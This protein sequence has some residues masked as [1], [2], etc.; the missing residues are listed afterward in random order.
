MANR[1]LH[2]YLRTTKRAGKHRSY[3]SPKKTVW[4]SWPTGW[5][6]ES[7]YTG[8]RRRRSA[9]WEIHEFTPGPHAFRQVCEQALIDRVD[10]AKAIR[11]A[12]AAGLFRK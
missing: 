7:L 4:V 1:N 5:W 6:E 3:H 8:K 12:E 2:R 10:I 11:C 9:W